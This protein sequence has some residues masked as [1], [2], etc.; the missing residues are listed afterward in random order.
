MRSPRSSRT[1]WRSARDSC[2]RPARPRPLPQRRRGRLLDTGPNPANGR[3][4]NLFALDASTI[5]AVGESGR[6]LRS[7]D[8]GFSFSSLTSLS[9]SLDDQYWRDLQNG[10]VVGQAA[11]RR[12]TDGGQSWQPIP[13]VS[14]S[15]LFFGG[16]IEFLDQELG[17][18][19]TDF[20]AYR[21]TNGEHPGP[22]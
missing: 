18:I 7:S 17:W 16:D 4:R 20:E 2:W 13:G 21:T 9:G 10:F 5:F 15:G 12:T 3:L 1:S 14:E 22:T 6:V 8:G 11:V 19:V